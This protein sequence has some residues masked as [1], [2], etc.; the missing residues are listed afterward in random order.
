MKRLSIAILLTLSFLS[1]QAQ[2]L[3]NAGREFWVTSSKNI[4][5][6]VMPDSALI[7][8]MG[9]T[10]CTG[11]IENPNTSFYQTFTVVP[12]SVLV[13]AIPKED[14]MCNVPNSP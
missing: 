9:D 3:T 5:S 6:D 11:Y 8:I 4:L 12:D 13:I 10:L 2:E 7:Y 14:I 1:L